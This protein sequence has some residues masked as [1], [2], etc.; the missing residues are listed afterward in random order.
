MSALNTISGKYLVAT[1]NGAVI[2]GVQEWEVTE[3]AD[4]L[5]GTTGLDQGFE[6]D[7]LGV[8]S[9][10]ARLT[11]VQNLATGPYIEIAMGNVLSDVKLYRS[12][13]DNQPAFIFPIM[14]V[15]ESKNGGRVKDRFTVN[16][17]ARAAGPYTRSDPGSG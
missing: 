6:N 17:T 7:D 2:A 13:T 1:V 8:F 4:R 15:Y 16:V 12:V 11:I 3:T 14:R 10:E 9:A 5:D